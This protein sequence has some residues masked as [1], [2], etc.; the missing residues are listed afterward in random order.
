MFEEKFLDNIVKYLDDYTVEL[1]ITSSKLMKS[2]AQTL[3]VSAVLRYEN[4]TMLHCSVLVEG[5]N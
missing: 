4:N 3:A 5:G 1:H 2:K